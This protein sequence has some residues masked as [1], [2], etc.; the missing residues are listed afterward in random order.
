MK[1]SI[2]SYLFLLC[3]IAIIS[4]GCIKADTTITFD[5]KD[6]M[7]VET[8]VL[9]PQELMKYAD[10]NTDTSKDDL[11]KDIDT[12][13]NGIKIE[14]TVQNID[15]KDG[16]GTRKIEICKNV[17]K[18]KFSKISMLI[19]QN[20]N[21][22]I[23]SVENYVFFKKYIFRGQLEQPE[24]TKT[25]T[26]DSKVNPNDLI[27][28]KLRVQ[29]PKQAIDVKSNTNVKDADNTNIYVWKIDYSKENP[30]NLEFCLINWWTTVSSVVGLLLLVVCIILGRKGKLDFAK[31]FQNLKISSNSKTT[32]KQEK[33][34]S[35]AK[36]IGI[37]LIILV[38]LG[39]S[40]FFSLPTI[41]NTLVDNS[42]KNVY[43]GETEK[44]M[45]MI[46]VANLLNTNKNN[47]ISKE[48]FAKGLSE[49]EK[50]DN[51]TAKAFFD[52]V[53]KTKSENS[54]KY[55]QELSDKAVS[56]LNANQLAKSKNLIEAAAKFDL[57]TAQ[58]TH[59]DFAKKNLALFTAKK[60]NEA[61]TV[62]DILLTLKPENHENWFRK[63]LVLMNL[64]R[65]KE[66]V[67]AFTKT[68]N[69]KNDYAIA[70]LDRG[71]IYQTKLADYDKAL[72]D[73]NQV[74]SY[75]SDKKQIALA[76]I[77]IAEIYTKK[78]DYRKA[79]DSAWMAKELYELL[80][81]YEKADECYRYFDYVAELECN[82]P[83]G[84]CYY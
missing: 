66:A 3:G 20:S 1:K 32:A 33:Q 23:L 52:L 73:F 53:A 49:L 18:A 21:G 63:S 11:T 58:K 77:S 82:R 72:Y 65:N 79:M 60:Y 38:G 59:A 13:A 17:S 71:Y 16:V 46:E 14:T 31:Y 28:S 57:K 15:S 64:N 56:A 2:L 27:S 54:Q 29:V 69:L 9:F 44:A 40:I 30:I 39:T 19:P 4:T 62:C 84:Y 10:S 12:E 35:P 25:K 55:S 42:I 26:S 74:I 22:S 67:E 7:K 24:K 76:R 80:G 51:T 5:N 36:I 43:V 37:S 61:L 81:N 70:Y 75:S 47:D 45:K 78:K 34:K 8:T 83:N 48:I 41:C 6:N 50:N 68:I